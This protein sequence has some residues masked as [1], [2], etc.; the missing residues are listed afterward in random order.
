MYSAVGNDDRGHALLRRQ[1]EYNIQD[2]DLTIRFVDGKNTATYLAI[3]EG[4]TNDLH[5]ACGDWEVMSEIQP[6]PDE[7]IAQADIYLVD[8]NA[9]M[10]ILRASATS[11]SETGCKV[12]FEPT[13]VPKV[14]HIAAD[15][16]F[17]R[18]L[19]GAFPNLDELIAMRDSACGKSPGSIINTDDLEDDDI[20]D[21]ADE[22]LEHM[23][24]EA[25]LVVTLGDRGVCLVSKK[26]DDNC[27]FPVD[28]V[29]EPVDVQ[30]C[31]GAGDTLCGAF[32]H[33]ILQGRSREDA[34]VWGMKAAAVSLRSSSRTIAP[35]LSD[36]KL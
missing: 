36:F 1:A 13:S 6:P 30:N 23:S 33:A 27:I 26:G 7:I 25:F 28:S 2:S 3:L 21:M 20:I 29:T 17:M 11:A 14:R 31:T 34:V 9:P 4:G 24:A 12:F 22:L 19:T 16:I 10:E 5:T 32:I 35:E 18:C 8:A 15:S